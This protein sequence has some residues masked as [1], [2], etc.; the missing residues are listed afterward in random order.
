MGVAR[1]AWF[2][3]VVAAMVAALT[4]ACAL[5]AAAYQLFSSA[6][7]DLSDTRHWR[8]VAALAVIGL[9]LLGYAT[10][11]AALCWRPADGYAVAARAVFT[12][13]IG[14][15]VVLM[16]RSVMTTSPSSD[17]CGMKW[18]ADLA[19]YLC[20]TGLVIVETAAWVGWWGR[21]VVG[22]PFTEA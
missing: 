3:A 8:H 4:G 16:V 15:V 21:K 19:P 1:L 2:G 18:L 12:A 9:A 13:A 22:S 20:S 7:L 6:S 14:T 10:A 17:D 11:H 5:A